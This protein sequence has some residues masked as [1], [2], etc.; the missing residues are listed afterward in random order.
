MQPRSSFSHNHPVRTVPAYEREVQ[1]CLKCHCP[2]DVLPIRISRVLYSNM[3]C[4]L[5]WRHMSFSFR[6]R[7]FVV[8]CVVCFGVIPVRIGTV[9]YPY[10]TDIGST[11]VPLF[12]ARITRLSLL[13][14]PENKA[15]KRKRTNKYKTLVCCSQTPNVDYDYSHK[16]LVESIPWGRTRCHDVFSAGSI[17][18]S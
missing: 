18:G 5:T 7:P 17:Q 8:S 1:T 3:I 9:S 16:T 11:S 12:Q 13:S 14:S 4:K 10:L 6:F 15:Y 2:K